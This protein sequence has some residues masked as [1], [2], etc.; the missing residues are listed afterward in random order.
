ME[1]LGSYIL[2]E[3][4]DVYLYGEQ[5]EDHYSGLDLMTKQLVIDLRLK[6]LM[7]RVYLSN[8]RCNRN[9]SWSSEDGSRSCS[10]DW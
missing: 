8:G 9:R 10:R 1:F 7:S 2:S 4:T 5:S 3:H 6:V